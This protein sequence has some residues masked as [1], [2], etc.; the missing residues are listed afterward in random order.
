M[1]CGLG[2]ITQDEETRDRHVLLI[3]QVPEIKHNPSFPFKLYS[4]LRQWSDLPIASRIFCF[5]RASVG[6]MVVSLLRSS[7]ESS[8]SLEIKL[9]LGTRRKMFASRAFGQSEAPKRNNGRLEAVRLPVS[10]GPPSGWQAA[11]LSPFDPYV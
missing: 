9:Y 4:F 7:V 2:L 5:I 6:G 3:V 1:F 8:S 10:T 11:S